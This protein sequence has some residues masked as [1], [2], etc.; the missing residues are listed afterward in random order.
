MQYSSKKLKKNK[1]KVKL[2]KKTKIF[3]K[4]DL[5]NLKSVANY[6]K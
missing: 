5:K 3:F 4:N 1:K 2:S 6:M